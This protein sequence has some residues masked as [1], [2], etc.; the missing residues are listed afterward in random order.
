MVEREEMANETI[1]FLPFGSHQS[2][3]GTIQYQIEEFRLAVCM[4]MS[5]LQPL[6]K[7]ITRSRQSPVQGTTHCRYW[8]E[9]FFD[10]DTTAR[11]PSHCVTCVLDSHGVA[12][13]ARGRPSCDQT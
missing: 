13:D 9:Y 7:Y 10:S 2:C 1:S 3:D 12:I 11:S 5:F 8:T 6:V 4:H